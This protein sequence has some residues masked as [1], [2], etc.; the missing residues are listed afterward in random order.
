LVKLE[1]SFWNTPLDYTERAV[2][3]GFH[4]EEDAGAGIA[5]DFRVRNFSSGIR[6]PP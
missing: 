6:K 2:R 3:Q 1:L 4:S 5:R